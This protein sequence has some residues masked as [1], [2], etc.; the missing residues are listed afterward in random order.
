MKLTKKRL[1]L[2]GMNISFEEMNVD[3]EKLEFSYLS[4]NLIKT[5][6]LSSFNF[7]TLKSLNLYNS[8]FGYNNAAMLLADSNNF[9]GLDIAVFGNSINVFK[10]EYRLQVNLY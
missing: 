1:I 2:S 8:K 4:E 5:I 10:K 7:D 9:P 3:K 6:D